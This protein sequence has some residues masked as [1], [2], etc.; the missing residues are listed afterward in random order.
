MTTHWKAILGVILIFILGFTS[1]VVCS[2]IFVQRKLAAFMQH[3]GATAE[4]A[5][6][7]RLVR[8]LNLDPKQKQQIHDYL[9]DNLQQRKDLNLQIQPQVRALNVQTFQ[10]INAVLRPDQQE[11]FRQNIEKFRNRFAK[12]AANADVDNLPPPPV[13]A[14]NSGAAPAPQR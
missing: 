14:A 4:A 8:N 9:L 12:A 2:S 5:M 11:I 6:E 3:P 7:K 10:Q 1:G 13:P